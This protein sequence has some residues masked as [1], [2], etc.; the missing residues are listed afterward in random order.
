MRRLKP[1]ARVIRSRGMKSVFGVEVGA[2]ERHHLL[3][4]VAE[5][6]TPAKMAPDRRG[7]RALVERP[8]ADRHVLRRL[9]EAERAEG[10]VGVA[11]HH[12]DPGAAVRE[13]AQVARADVVGLPGE[14]VPGDVAARRVA[15]HGRE[16]D[17]HQDARLGD[18]LRGGRGVA[19]ESVRPI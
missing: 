19:A 15:Q 17:L 12:G 11:H 6:I 13:L 16:A 5:S 14:A 3:G 1:A 2:G 18:R 7:E 10:P 9:G 8:D 4:D